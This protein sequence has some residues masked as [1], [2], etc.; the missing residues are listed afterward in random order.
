MKNKMDPIL[1]RLFKA[2]TQMIKEMIKD[3]I[4]NG[5]TKEECYENIRSIEIDATL[6]VFNRKTLEG[7]AD[8]KTVKA[9]AEYQKSLMN[10][11]NSEVQKAYT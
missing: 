9:F 1:E 8:P 4:S 5:D 7:K 2:D 10:F 3:C 6:D 11:L